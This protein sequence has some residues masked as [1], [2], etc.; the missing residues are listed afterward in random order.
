M[1]T[2]RVLLNGCFTSRTRLR[3]TSLSFEVSD[4]L[5][6]FLGLHKRACSFVPSVLTIEAKLSAASWTNNLWLG[7]IPEDGLG[8]LF[9]DAPASIRV[10]FQFV[11]HQELNELVI[12]FGQHQLL[13]F[14]GLR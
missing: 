9:V 13:H 11:E 2:A 3:G 6:V 14:L 10:G 5:L 8:A 7:R 12:G 4:E 1:I